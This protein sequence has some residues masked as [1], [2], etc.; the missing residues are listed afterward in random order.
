MNVMPIGAGWI[1]VIC[2][3]MFSGKSEELIRRLR[4]AQIARL[5]LQ[6][7][8]PRIDDRYH[9]AKIV[10]HSAVSIDAVPADD[11]SQIA[12]WIRTDTRVVG[13]DEAQF[14]D[15]GIVDLA[16]RLANQGLRVLVAGLD[17]D[18]TSRPFDP[19]PQLCAL[20][21][22]V[23]KVLAI[24]ARC[25]APAGRSQRLAGGGSRVEVGAADTYEARCRRCHVPRIEPTTGTLFSDANH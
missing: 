8:K 4:R 9:A 20:A 25:G 17:Q 10:S 3:P 13:I 6:A 22:S 18:Y 16:E 23:T 11:S 12:G 14:F 24:C 19:M 2:G 21:E 5:P 15:A 7:F 1:E